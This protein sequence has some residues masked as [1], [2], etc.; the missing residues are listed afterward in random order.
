M[1]LK[2]I[3]IQDFLSIRG[4]VA[5]DVD[6]KVT[7]LLG[8]NDHGKS[9]ILRALTCLNKEQAITEDD[10]NWDAETA[11]SISFDFKLNSEEQSEL[12][13]MT[14][15]AYEGYTEQVVKLRTLPIEDPENPAANLL[16]LSKLATAGKIAVPSTVSL[17]E[18]VEA[19]EKLADKIKLLGDRAASGNARFSRIGIETELLFEGTLWSD[20]PDSFRDFLDKHL[21]RIELFQP[22]S[23]TLQDS[24]ASDQIG[25][26]EFEF[27]QGVFF[28]AGLDPLK[29]DS[30]FTQSDITEQ[31]LDKASKKLD[32]ELR[33]IWAQGVDLQLHFE[34]R[35]RGNSIE[36][37]ALDPAVKSRKTRMSKRSAGVTQFFRLSMVLHA[38]RMKHRANSYIFVFDEPGIYLH[39]KGQKDLIQVFEQ[40]SDETQIL[41]ATHSLFLLNQNYPERH[42]LIIRDEQ[43][44]KVDQKPYRAN[45]RF[46]TDAL[47]VQLTA[48]ILFSPAVLLVEG[49]SDPLYIYELFR[50]LNRS[51]EIDGDANMLGIYSFENLPNLR[52]LLQTFK[53]ENHSAEVAVLCD[54]DKAGKRTFKAI[55]DL[56]ETRGVSRLVLDDS[57]V[58][59][60]YALDEDCFIK[61]AIEAIHTAADAEKIT[62]P[63]NADETISESWRT[64][65]REPKTHTADWFKT[66]AKEL[67]KNKDGA[68]KVALARNYAFRC[69]EKLD[70]NPSVTRKPRGISLCRDVVTA[71]K[72]PGTRA[73]QMLEVS[74]PLVSPPPQSEGAT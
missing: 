13:R 49:D 73:K 58:V 30:L 57:C 34:L 48:N 18:K 71:L 50:Q 46:A 61:G 17:Q 1:V 40:L 68:S 59:E 66:I 41:Y 65:L 31:A 32:G 47:G 36:F 27:L 12:L 29:S 26:E 6:K 69:R 9:N 7:I 16:L 5:V 55:K 4:E 21:P 52:F 72:L 42:R 24:V 37:M 64:H 33:Q 14:R 20:L 60:D 53:H 28:Y 39:P 54:G 8:A 15:D 38:R 2:R 56:C 45:W 19:L 63:G 74:G 22:T 25:R 51:A 3:T 11:P 44:T 35:H 67:L 23:G 10:R 43:G 62:L 70:V